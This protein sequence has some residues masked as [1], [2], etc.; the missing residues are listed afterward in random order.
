MLFLVPIDD[1]ANLILPF[2][3]KEINEVVSNLKSDK[4]PGPDGFNTDFMKKCWP[5]TKRIFMIYAR[6]FSIMIFV[7][8]V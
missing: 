1:L 4:S 2:S 6:V 3:N 8:K 5:V 7:C